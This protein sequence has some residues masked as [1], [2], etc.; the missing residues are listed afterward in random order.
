M[1]D[2]SSQTDRPS[3]ALFRYRS[4]RSIIRNYDYRGRIH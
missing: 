3:L 1:I 4:A 2:G